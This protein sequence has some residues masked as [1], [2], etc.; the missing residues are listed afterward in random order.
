MWVIDA[1]RPRVTTYENKYRKQTIYLYCHFSVLCINSPFD[2]KIFTEDNS[3]FTEDNSIFT[4]DNRGI[5]STR[6]CVY[7]YKIKDLIK[8]FMSNRVVGGCL[9]YLKGIDHIIDARDFYSY[10]SRDDYDE[11]IES[12]RRINYL[13]VNI[14]IQ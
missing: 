2:N 10:F 12:L 7:E 9:N 13:I 8:S 4:E 14:L 3:I 11:T 6:F 5:Y 1:H